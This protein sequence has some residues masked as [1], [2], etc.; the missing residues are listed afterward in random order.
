MREQILVGSSERLAG[1]PQDPVDRTARE[2]AAKQL[3]HQLHE[4][5]AG[6]TVADRQRRDRGPIRGPNAPNGTPAG[7]SARAV[8][9]QPGQRNRC[10][11]CSNTSTAIGGSS[12]T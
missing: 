1:A 10:S 7:S 5:T 8:P 12:K 11:Q 6:D 9:P 3:A 2:L 4:V